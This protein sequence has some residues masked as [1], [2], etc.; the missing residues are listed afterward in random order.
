MFILRLFALCCLLTTSIHVVYGQ[1]VL[2]SSY[3]S[4][5]LRSGDF[6]VIGKTG[7]L[8]YTYRA[9]SGGYFL[10]AYN[11]AMEKE[12]VVVLDFFPGK[13][14]HTRFVN[15]NDK[16]IVLYQAVERNEVVQYAAL[17]DHTGR[18][19]KPPL[20]L[21]S[22]KT[23]IFGAGG[24][25]Y[26]SSAVS[27]DKTRILVY[28]MEERA[29]ELKMSGIWIDDQL[30]VTGRGQA[31]FTTENDLKYDEGV[32]ANDGSFY[33]PVYTPVGSKNYMDRMWILQLPE[34]GR[35]FFSVEMPLDNLFATSVYMKMDQYNNRIYTAG[36]FSGRK[37][38]NY[39]GVLFAYY[40]F[41]DSSFHNR[42]MIAFG[43]RL[44]QATG[45][46]NLKKAFDDFIP[47]QMIIKKD[48]GFV[49]IAEQF[50]VTTRNTMPAW[51]GYYSYYYGGM[52][53]Q[54]IREY[55]YHDIFAL[56]YD[57]AGNNEWHAFVRKNQYSQEDGGIFSSYAL[58]N[59]GGSLGF[60]F[61]DHN[62]NL[63]KIQ[64]AAMDGTGKVEMHSLAAGAA[65]D[66]DWLPRAGKQ[67]GLREMI[68]P[69]LRKKQIC[70]AKIMF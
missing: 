31:V 33:L 48:G 1:D 54:L 39:E 37:N 23:G 63:S 21:T 65:N 4:F 44:R 34:G 52:G 11:E 42:R 43:E 49:L 67:V 22:V 29:A 17:L 51:G 58:V 53:G 16:I 19:K 57:G 26:F 41:A 55:N 12:A 30:T 66:P 40:D 47:R 46:G 35:K 8:I 2:Y 38:G 50:F 9:G 28:R 45:G 56:S 13:I 18:L 62:A 3:E 24:G 14:Q 5:D 70:F 6:A 20:R 64:F 68:V 27:D 15:Y 69:C 10:D 7:Q 59:T 60:L 32:L 25:K 61:N 36:F